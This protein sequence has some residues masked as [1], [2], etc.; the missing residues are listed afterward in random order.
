M[1]L[2]LVDQVWLGVSTTTATVLCSIIVTEVDTHCTD[3]DQQPE[4]LPGILMYWKGTAAPRFPM[5]TGTVQV[6]VKKANL[7]VRCWAHADPAQ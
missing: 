5:Y 4:P 2:V 7:H 3:V 1:V 6:T